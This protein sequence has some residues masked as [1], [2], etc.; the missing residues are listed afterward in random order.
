VEYFLRLR[1][2]TERAGTQRTGPTGDV[3]TGDALAAR[4]R[5]VVT[6]QEEGA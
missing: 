1:R 3:L 2:R 6:E 4:V 5:A